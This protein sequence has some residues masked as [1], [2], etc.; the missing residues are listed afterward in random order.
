MEEVLCLE[1]RLRSRPLDRFRLLLLWDLELDLVRLMSLL[2]EDCL[3]RLRCE[4]DLTSRADASLSLVLSRLVLGEAMA[5]EADLRFSKRL[6]RS[7]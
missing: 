5:A 1:D 4:E 3:T 7:E 6:D 2:C